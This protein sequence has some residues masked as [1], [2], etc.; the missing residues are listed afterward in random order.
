MS[1]LYE[2]TGKRL[3]LQNKLE[4]MDLDAEFVAD[5]IESE[6]TDLQEKITDYG[7]V[8]R[9]R[10]S[11]ADAMTAEIVRMT[12][13]RDA[14]V[15]RIA[16]I[17][18]WLLLNMV[19]CKISKIECAAFTVSVKENPQSV[20]VLCEAEIPPEYMKTPAP[21]PPVASPDKRAILAD[22]KEGKIIPGCALK[23]TTKLVIK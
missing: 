12:E 8:I 1:S 19:A 22:M 6:S 7:Y 23:R 9:T 15:K 11:F 20:D 2:L 21:K 4:S 16:K 18:E 5:T 17:E 14:E 3:E 10:S 13:R